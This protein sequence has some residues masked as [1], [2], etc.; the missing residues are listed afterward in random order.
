LLKGVLL[1]ALLLVLLQV[2]SYAYEEWSGTRAWAK[3]KAQIEAAGISLDP[4]T[5]IPPPVPDA[6]NFAALPIFQLEPDP[7][8]KGARK[9]LALDK[10]LDPICDNIFYPNIDTYEPGKLPY[11]GYWEKGE[12]TDKVVVQKQLVEFCQHASPPIQVP[13]GATPSELLSLICPALAELRAENLKRPFCRFN[14]DYS[15]RDYS[16]SL[17]ENLELLTKQIKLAK[18]LSYEEHL[19]LLS[20]QPQLA[21]DD[22]KVN[23]KIISGLQK[24]PLLVSGLVTNGVVAIHLSVVSEGVALHAWNDQQLKELD[25]NLGEIDPLTESQ[26]CLRGEFVTNE[27]PLIA[28]RQADRFFLTRLTQKVADE[29]GQKVDR[30]TYMRL[31]IDTWLTPNGAWDQS[32]ADYGPLILPGNMQMIDLASRRVFPENQP[33]DLDK[34]SQV[35][36]PWYRAVRQFAY[37]QVHVDEAGIACRLERYRLAHGSYPDALPGLLAEYGELPHDIMNGAA[38]HYKLNGDGTYV[39]YS[40]GWNQK[41]DGGQKGPSFSQSA[42]DPDWIWTNYPDLKKEK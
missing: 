41:D 25:T 5:Y 19:A 18:A 28:R 12:T 39:L 37:A 9:L 21:L 13:T 4:N 15:N 23:W 20:G 24:E 7:K 6:E 35:A 31:W 3:A 16:K 33:A 34:A 1:I 17:P 42:S 14:V 30:D 10:A 27:I 2:L 40:V 38:Y 26:L 29:N 36:R 22:F 11:L 32:L 8:H